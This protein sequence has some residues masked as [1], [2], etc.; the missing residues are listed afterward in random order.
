MGYEL[1]QPD[2]G[3]AGHGTTQLGGGSPG[4]HAVHDGPEEGGAGG[5][6]QSSSQWVATK[7]APATWVTS[8]VA[9][10]AQHG[11][12]SE[13]LRVHGHAYPARFPGTGDDEAIQVGWRHNGIVAALVHGGGASTRNPMLTLYIHRWFL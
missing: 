12:T 4:N 1:A 6:V 9:R 5:I 10:R 7:D 11:A 2:A 8:L 3:D 13:L